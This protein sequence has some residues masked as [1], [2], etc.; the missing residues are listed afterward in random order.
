MDRQQNAPVLSPFFKGE[1]KR[2]SDV[3]QAWFQKLKTRDDEIRRTPNKTFTA[4]AALTTWDLGTVVQ[5][6][7]GSTDVTGQLPVVQDTD[8]W[9]WITI[10]RTGTGKLT[11]TADDASRIEYSS[12]GGS[13]LC[14]EKLRKA[15]NVTLQLVSK[16]QW[17]ITAGLGIWD[18]D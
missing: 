10:I 2:I 1:V 3:W 7:I 11:L 15:A 17:A 6:S 8:V 18:I 9:A 12:T 5:F 16:N 14:V 4:D 13:I